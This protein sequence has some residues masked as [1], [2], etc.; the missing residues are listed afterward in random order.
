MWCTSEFIGVM[1]R[2][3]GGWAAIDP[4]T[5][6]G[7]VSNNFVR[8]GGDGYSMFRDDAVNA[9]DYGPDVA[10]VVAE[11]LAEH[12]PYMPYTDGRISIR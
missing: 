7:V 3:E 5:T 4:D 1:V 11:Y 9:Y 12:T 8:S 6:Y 2:A 10:D